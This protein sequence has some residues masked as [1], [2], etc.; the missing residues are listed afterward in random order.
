[1]LLLKTTFGVFASATSKLGYIR[2]LIIFRRPMLSWTQFYIFA[3]SQIRI[4]KMPESN[5]VLQHLKKCYCLFTE[6][7]C[8][9]TETTGPTAA[10]DAPKLL[11][12]GSKNLRQM[13]LG[14]HKIFSRQISAL[15]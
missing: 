7:T 1:M 10:P 14:T 15:T 3:S 8:R 13:V 5:H 11:L 2:K 9:H 4:E 6:H 12:S